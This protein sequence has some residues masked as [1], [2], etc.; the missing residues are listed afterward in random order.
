[1]FLNNTLHHHYHDLNQL[2]IVQ[3]GTCI[4]GDNIYPISFSKFCTLSIGGEHP[5]SGGGSFLPKKPTALNGFY[6][7][8]TVDTYYGGYIAIGV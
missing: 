8:L 7:T 2:P 5:Y 1:M 4:N 6:Y 3:W